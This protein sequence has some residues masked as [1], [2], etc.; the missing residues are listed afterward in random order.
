VKNGKITRS[1]E[2]DPLS[3]SY[4]TG[5]DRLPYETL[6]VEGWNID[7]PEAVRIADEAGGAEFILVMLALSGTVEYPRWQVV[8]GPSTTEKG[9]HPGLAVEINATSGEVVKT[10]TET[11]KIY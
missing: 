6:D 10:E 3:F 1:L 5:E 7:S 2:S 8:F 4:G 9:E 11:F